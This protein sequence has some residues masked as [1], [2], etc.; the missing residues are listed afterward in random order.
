MIP[1]LDL[2]AARP[3]LIPRLRV[4]SVEHRMRRAG[5][6]ILDHVIEPNIGL[7][8]VRILAVA[9]GEDYTVRDD[10]RLGAVHV[11]RDP[12]GNQLRLAV[13]LLHF[14]GDDSAVFHFAML[15]RDLEGRVLGTPDGS[16]HPARALRI[17]PGGHGS[18]NARPRV[19]DLFIA[20]QRSP[21]IGRAMIVA[22]DR[23]D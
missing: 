1:G 11:T 23:A 10:G 4:E 9:I 19:V 20:E 15:D 21:I 12:G 5:D 3:Q 7:G 22:A 8:L 2:I 16:E 13:P 6:T 18:P 17:L 14:E